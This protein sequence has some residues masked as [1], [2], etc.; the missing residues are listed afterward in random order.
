MVLLTFNQPNLDDPTPACPE[1]Y[2]MVSLNATKISHHLYPLS[3]WHPNASLWTHT[4]LS[5]EYFYP[6]GSWQSQ[7]HSIGPQ[8]SP[9]YFKK[10][11]KHYLKVQN[12]S[13]IWNS[14]QSLTRVLLWNKK[15]V[16]YLQHVVT[17]SKYSHSRVKGSFHSKTKRQQ[18]NIKPYSSMSTLGTCDEITGL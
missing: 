10:Q 17:Q 18:G 9:Q 7:M 4:F 11:F 2:S 5:L 1:I 12:L 15:Q 6:T 8:K 3:A 13:L 14:R 16:A